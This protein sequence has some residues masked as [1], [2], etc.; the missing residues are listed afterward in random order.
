[1]RLGFQRTVTEQVYEQVRDSIRSG[2]LAPGVRIDQAG[3][4]RRFGTSIVPVREAL[5]RLQADGLVR[6]VPHRG[7]FVEELS[8]EVLIDIY[9]MRELLEEDAARL[10]APYM[11]EAELARLEELTNHMAEATERQDYAAL[12]QLNREFHFTIYRAA[13][14]EHLLQIIEQLWDQG[15]HYRRIYTELPER[16]RLA[17]AEH[18]AILEACRRRDQDAMGITVRHHIHQTTVG[19]LDQMR[20]AARPGDPP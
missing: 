20:A 18:R 12:F 19:L 3:L 2:A 10:A 14:R 5:A 15:D 4:A 6:I 7:A 1:M 11:G 16:A 9:S 8:P 13:R 17:L